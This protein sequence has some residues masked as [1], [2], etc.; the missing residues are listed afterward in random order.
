MPAQHVE[1]V[2]YTQYRKRQ[3]IFFYTCVLPDRGGKW[4]VIALPLANSKE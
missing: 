3:Y 2:K 4:D 1:K